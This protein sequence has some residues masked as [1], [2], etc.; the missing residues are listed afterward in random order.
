MQTIEELQRQLRQPGT[1]SDLLSPDEFA[2]EGALAYCIAD[3]FSKTLKPNQTR[4]IFH[5]FKQLEQQHSQDAD[6][7]KLRV[8]DTSR[9]TLL[10]PELAYGVGR[11]LIPDDFYQALKACLQSGKMQTVADLRRLVQFLSAVVAYQKYHARKK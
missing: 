3:E 1:L 10:I 4:R 2:P 11:D 8:E 6:E 9:L 7:V 5:T